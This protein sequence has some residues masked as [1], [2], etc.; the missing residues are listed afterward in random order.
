MK[1]VFTNIAVVKKPGYF[2]LL[3]LDYVNCTVY[4]WC[5]GSTGFQQMIYRSGKL[6]LVINPVI[7]KYIL[8]SLYIYK[9]VDLQQENTSSLK[10]I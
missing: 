4:S 2:F 1:H 5:T 10:D 8:T 9:N 7:V 6:T 3:F